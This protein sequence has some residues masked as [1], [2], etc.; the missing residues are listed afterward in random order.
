MSDETVEQTAPVEPAE[1]A[2]D[3]PQMPEDVEERF[4]VKQEYLDTVVGHAHKLFNNKDNLDIRQEATG[5]VVI[6][7]TEDS[8]GATMQLG[9]NIHEDKIIHVLESV[10]ARVKQNG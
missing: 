10:L 2:L 4:K 8:L 9:S 7:F 6:L 1:Q 5:L 3:F